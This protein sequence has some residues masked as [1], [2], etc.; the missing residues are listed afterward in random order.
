[1]AINFVAEEDIQQRI[2]KCIQKDE[3]I[4]ETIRRLKKGLKAE[5]GFALSSE[6]L[7][8]KGKI[9][10]PQ[11]DD[12]R[13]AII[14]QHHDSRTAGHPGLKSTE[15]LIQRNYYWSRMRYM[16]QQYAEGCNICQRV[17][18]AQHTPYGLLAQ[19]LILNTK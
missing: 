13:K 3:I 15:E 1:M 14:E 9:Y 10:V 17:K 2:Q 16:I 18:P 8:Y 4:A 5:E 6:I 7:Q 11:F 19:L 12:I